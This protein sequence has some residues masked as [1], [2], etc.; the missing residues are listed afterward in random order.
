MEFGQAA[1]RSGAVPAGPAP[2]QQ[3]GRHLVR[4]LT[5]VAAPSRFTYL[6]GTTISYEAAGPVVRR[7]SDGE[8]TTA[9]RSTWSRSTLEAVGAESPEVV[10]LVGRDVHR[11]LVSHE[12]DRI[13]RAFH[14]DASRLW[15][16]AVPESTLGADPPD[17][18]AHDA[19]LLSIVIDYADT[20]GATDGSAHRVVALFLA[21]TFG[22]VVPA[23]A[24]T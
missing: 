23:P 17:T 4:R 22:P 9:W 5:E 16:L 24:R 18:E 3:R 11:A 12:A 10:S 8:P 21:G 15:S 2:D 13:C 1:R 20:S 19:G 7:W 6:P 14:V